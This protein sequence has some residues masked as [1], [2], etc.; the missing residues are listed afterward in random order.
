MAL[1]LAALAF[2]VLVPAAP[3]MSKGWRQAYAM[4]QANSCRPHA[5]QHAAPGA[6]FPVL[7]LCGLPGFDQ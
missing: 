5:V 1:L 4:Q 3:H 7:V 2:R 6:I